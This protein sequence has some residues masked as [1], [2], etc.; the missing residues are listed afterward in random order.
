MTKHIDTRALAI[1]AQMFIPLDKLKKSPDNARKVPHSEA[2][3]TALRGSIAAKGI[4]QNLIV[5]PEAG[6]DGA[7]TGFYLV[8]VG[9]GRRIVQTRRA[10]DGDIKDDEP[11]PCIIRQ[12]DDAQEVSLDENV[13]REAMHPADQFDA[14]RALNTERGMGVEDIAARFGVTAQTVRQ[15][16]RL[17]A[18]SPV[19]MQAYRDEALTLDQL[20]AFAITEDHARQE[21]VFD[22]LPAYSREPYHI[23]RF[24]TEGHVPVNDRRVKFIGAETYL[25]AG[26]RIERD[27]FTEDGGGFFIDAG[28]LDQLTLDRLSAIAR[29]IEGAEGWK[30]SEAHIDFPHGHGMRRA[31]PQA[32]TLSQ[33]DAEALQSA[34]DALLEL[35]TQYEAYDSLPDDADQRMTAL[36][37]EIA[38]LEDLTT[39][40]DPDDVQRGGIIV[41]LA[42][43]GAAR[44]ERG[45]IRLQD[46]VPEPEPSEEENGED[47]IGN[48][49][50]T[51]NPHE[52]VEADDEA[53][54]G[55][56]LPDSLIRDLTTHRSLALRLALG[57]QPELAARALAHKLILDIFFPHQDLAGLEV[58]A[59]SS[60][61]ACYAE[62]LDESPTAMALQQRHDAWAA[63]LPPEAADLWDYL[64]ALEAET[65]GVL[66][67]HCV[68]QTVNIVKQP[69]G[70][71]H[72][73]K[74][75]HQL[76]SA[77]HLAMGEHWRPTA[78]SYFGRVTKAHI[79]A[80]VR[81]AA[82]EEA[83]ERLSTLKKQAMAETAEQLMVGTDW[84]PACLRTPDEPAGLIGLSDEGAA[85]EERDPIEEE[86]GCGALS[87]DAPPLSEAAE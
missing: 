69:Y 26:G 55:K 52:P 74:A 31:Y 86:D 6:E 41:S 46:L 39:G 16:L 84:L 36:Q 78:R 81:E 82:G 22:R 25:N 48:A 45:L 60:F 63:Q 12:Q 33:E 53:D 42:Y 68:A 87:E 7:E 19:L 85:E 23:R 24:L 37:S 4:L 35:S 15:R 72:V 77:A 83:A 34:H 8:T 11:M 73:T 66:I 51:D 67:A 18:V 40:Y 27:L 57:E 28:L 80:A 64:M 9:E 3:L 38:R 44:I 30:W 59:T 32:R 17:A 62:G 10:K 1:G 65:L 2:A 49:A 54:A 79:L 71:P 61:I 76:A 50:S 56:P 75:G 21:A 29:G 13:T 20:M 58:K 43:D 47:V 5:K 70:R 14:F